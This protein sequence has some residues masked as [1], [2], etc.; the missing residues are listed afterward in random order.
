MLPKT[1]SMLFTFKRN[2]SDL[3]IKINNIEI[4]RKSITKFLGVQIDDKLNWKA[5]ITH[6]CSKVSKSI[7]IL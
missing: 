4:E 5:H 2:V 7:A 1:H 6:I 3:K